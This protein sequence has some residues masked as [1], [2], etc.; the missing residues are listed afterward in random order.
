MIWYPKK[1]QVLKCKSQNELKLWEIEKCQ[2]YSN[3]TEIYL[4]EGN[5]FKK[6]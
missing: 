4:D 1:V 3:A 5:Y 2:I 6:H